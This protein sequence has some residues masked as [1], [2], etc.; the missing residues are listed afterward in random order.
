MNIINNNLFKQIFLKKYSTI[1]LF[2]V[3][4]NTPIK[5]SKKSLLDKDWNKF[6]N[7]YKFTLP[8]KSL[9][10]DNDEELEYLTKYSLLQ[11]YDYYR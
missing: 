3:L 1:N 6:K 10:Y 9:I 4:L 5:L 8:C 7:I 2:I 11:A